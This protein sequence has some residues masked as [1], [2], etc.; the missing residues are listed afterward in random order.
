M[1]TYA[2]VDISYNFHGT[3]KLWGSPED[4]EED[5]KKRVDDFFITET[6]KEL[7]FSVKV[8]DGYE[9]RSKITNKVFKAFKIFE[10]SEEV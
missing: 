9:I 5:I 3:V 8:H 7:Y 4:A 2:V 10:C 6:E 1:N